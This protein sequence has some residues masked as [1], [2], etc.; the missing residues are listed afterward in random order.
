MT[1]RFAR[2]FPALSVVALFVTTFSVLAIFAA[3]AI[4]QNPVPFINNPLVPDATAP[5]GAGFTL[6]VNGAGFVASSTVNWNGSPLATAFI[7]GIQLTATVPASNVAAGSTVSVTVVNPSPGGGASNT[8]YFSIAAAE[9]SVS[10]LPAVTYD[11]VGTLAW[12]LEVADLNGDGVPDIV[13][14]SDSSVAVLLGSGGGAFKPAVTYSSGGSYNW[15]LAIGDLNRDGKLDLV[16]AAFCSG[17][18]GCLGVLLGNGDGTFQPAVT[19]SDDYY[20]WASGEGIYFPVM[21]ADVNGDGIPDLVVVSQTSENY[22]DGSVGIL[23]GNGDGT[24]KPVVTYD[25]GGF[26]TFSGVLADVNGDG[27]LDVIVTNCGPSGST[28]CTSDGTVGVLLGNGDGTFQPVK[29]Y[30]T[31]GDTSSPLAVADVNRDGKLDILVGNNCPGN[32]SGDGSFAVLLGNGDGTF[33]GAVTYDTGGGGVGAIAVA[34]LNGDGYPDVVVASNQVSVWLGNGDGTFAQLPGVYA[35]GCCQIYLADL[36]ADD[37][38]DLVA[39]AGTSNSV[40]VLP[41]NGDGTFQGPQTYALGGSGYSWGT[42]S[43]VVGNGR[44]ALLSANW[45]GNPCS[46]YEGTVGVLLQTAGPTPTSAVLASALNPSVYGQPVTLTATVSSTSGTP[47][48]TVVFYDGGNW[49]GSATLASG[50]AAI[51]DSALAAGSHS[52]TAAYQ[53]SSTYAS[54]TS[55]VLIQVVNLATTTT[56]LASSAN[57]ARVKHHV[58]YTATVASQYGGAA[59]GT[60]TFQDGGVT[61]ATVALS[62]N[63]AACTTSYSRPGIHSITATYSGDASNGGSISPVLTEEIGSLPYKST[64]AVTTSGSPSDVGQPVTFT[65]TVSSTD[66]AIPDGELVTFY[67]GSSEIGTGT[68]AGGV[69]TFTTSSLTAKTHTIKATYAGDATFKPSSGKL[70]QVVDKYATTTALVSSLNPS[71]YGQA[72]TFTATV[73]SSGPTPTG[74]VVFKDGAT[75][76]GSG[77]LSA[78]AAS[79]TK[80]NL[81]AGT[82]SITAEYEGDSDN[83]SSTSSVLDQVV[84]PN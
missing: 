44:P 38:L 36:G 41:G 14:T 3:S 56:S 5:G 33:Q 48:G 82:H 32:C 66:G 46:P 12:D 53:G 4:A 79:L 63:Q 13:V 8:L 74:K 11:S 37:K 26:G 51:S 47:T 45:C 35:A 75:T 81:A 9:T 1:T 20:E 49:I 25:S 40:D 65:A 7:S 69:A 64:T 34:D 18:G 30:S 22:G 77:I 43:D 71:A 62:R 29:T 31:G 27:K 39:V 15:G 54:S 59:S 57:P 80:K 72:V 2:K 58:T 84:N 52:V 50:S 19:Y 83:A 16:A 61:I 60:A 21:I 17:I 42:V 78:G 70:T 6:T 24:F 76:I 23:L 67:D 55:S 10:F 73:T 28:D 68:T